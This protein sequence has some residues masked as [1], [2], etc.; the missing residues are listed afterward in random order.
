MA[1]NL[2]SDQ[3][4]MARTPEKPEVTHVYDSM[5]GMYHDPVCNTPAAPAYMALP[6]TPMPFAN[7]R[8]P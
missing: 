1:E 5:K 7:L 4:V 3:L 8:K 6:A 2:M